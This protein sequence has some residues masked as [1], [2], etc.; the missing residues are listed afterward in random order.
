MQADTSATENA[1]TAVS[2][3]KHHP[4]LL[5]AYRHAFDVPEQTRE[6]INSAL[7]GTDA[8]VRL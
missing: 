8:E 6:N 5:E 7:A 3:V 2:L 1:A 4:R